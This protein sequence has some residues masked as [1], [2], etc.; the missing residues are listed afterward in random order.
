MQTQLTTADR[1]PEQL[2]AA[3]RVDALRASID[4]IDEMLVSL[5]GER[6]RLARAVGTAKRAAALP[7]IDGTREHDVIQRIVDHAS[8]HGVSEAE[9]R[10]LADQLIRLARTTQGLP[11]VSR[12]EA[13]AA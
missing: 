13:T 2:R 1:T 5:I 7:P 9:A 3:E 4:R 12:R 11:T 10:A 6:Q 8:D